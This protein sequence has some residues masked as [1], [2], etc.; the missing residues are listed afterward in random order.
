MEERMLNHPRTLAQRFYY[1]L[2]L[3]FIVM[4]A[5][6]FNRFALDP[7]SIYEATDLS[8]AWQYSL[9]YP[10]AETKTMSWQEAERITA[11]EYYLSYDL[12]Q[13]IEEPDFLLFLQEQ[14][15][16]V[17]LD[18]TLLYQTRVEEDKDPGFTFTKIAL[19]SDY[20]NKKL[21]IR[22]R[23]PYSRYNSWFI[24]GYLLPSDATKSFL[25]DQN[26]FTQVLGTFCFFL[27]FGILLYYLWNVWR[28][29]NAD[30]S[31]LCLGLFTITLGLDSFVSVADS[32]LFLPAR[33]HSELYYSLLLVFPSLLNCYLLAKVRYYVKAFRIFTLSVAG[34]ALVTLGLHLLEILPL[35]ISSYYYN[36]PLIAGTFITTLLAYLEKRRGN[37]FYVYI[38]PIFFLTALAN[39]VSFIANLITWMP[40]LMLLRSLSFSLLGIVICAYGVFSYIQEEQRRA[41]ELSLLSMRNAVLEENQLALALHS[42]E[43]RFMK[44]ENHH[45][46]QVLQ[47]FASGGKFTDIHDYLETLT[48]REATTRRNNNQRDSYV[49][50]IINHY[51][52]LSRQQKIEAS[53][54]ITGQ[55]QLSLPVTDLTSLLVNVLNPII[56][57]TTPSLDPWLKFTMHSDGETLKVTCDYVADKKELQQKGFQY[58]QLILKDLAKRYHGC[59]TLT[60]NEPMQQ[61]V[62]VLNIASAEAMV[63]E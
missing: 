24:K 11:T 49:S 26:F 12:T 10:T 47:D 48:T 40:D 22:V 1:T 56:K 38:F 57:A 21:V 55:D 16:K 18:G 27:G 20:Q 32:Y 41:Q 33:V 7:H 2:P 17:T 37:P 30:L 43:V 50:L 61:L 15:I 23:S 35:A 39:V 8:K 53:F 52:K 14:K 44:N 63:Y 13:A 58:A 28:N 31:F 34:V 9:T 29:K 54:A 59:C 45:H 19:P 6:L 46:Y 25:L 5:L 62:I 3:I 60:E 4:A 42:Q 51:E 36:V